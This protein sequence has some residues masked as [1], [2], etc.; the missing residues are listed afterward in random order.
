MR[1]FMQ[2]DGGEIQIGH[3]QIDIGLISKGREDAVSQRAGKHV[4]GHHTF[5][6]ALYAD[7]DIIWRIGIVNFADGFLII[8]FRVRERK[9]AV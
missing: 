6:T 9:K 1:K 8:F 5:D 2:A 3:L 7:I 4:F